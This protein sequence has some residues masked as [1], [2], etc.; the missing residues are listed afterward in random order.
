[1]AFKRFYFE[2]MLQLSGTWVDTKSKAYKAILATPDLA[3]MMARLT[4]AHS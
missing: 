1:M 3:P 4:A 2:E